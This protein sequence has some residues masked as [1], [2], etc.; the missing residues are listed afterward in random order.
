MG[1]GEDNH[2][3]FSAGLLPGVENIMGVRLPKL[4]ELA[5]K[6]VRENWQ[7]LCSVG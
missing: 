3:A 5:K 7:G 2:R 4:R 1:Y 6:L